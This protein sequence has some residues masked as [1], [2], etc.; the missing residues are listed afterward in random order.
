[1]KE[2]ALA[3]QTN[4]LNNNINERDECKEEEEEEEERPAYHIDIF[5]GF[6]L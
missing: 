3:E 2:E 4:L 5:V 6:Q 1:M